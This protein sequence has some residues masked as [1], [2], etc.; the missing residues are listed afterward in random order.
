[1]SEKL[2][3]VTLRFFM[4]QCGNRV[5][6]VEE[7]IKLNKQGISEKKYSETFKVNYTRDS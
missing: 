6:D 5:L 3:N 2:L 4:L 7:V 1:M